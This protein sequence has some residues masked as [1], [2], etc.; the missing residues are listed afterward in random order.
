MSVLAAVIVNL[1]MFYIFDLY[2]IKSIFFMSGRLIR[3]VIAVI[4]AVAALTIIL[5][6][7]T[8]LRITRIM[9]MQAPLIILL[10]G[11]WR[12]LFFRFSLKN[13]S[14]SNVA[15]VGDDL[16]NVSII[17]EIEKERFPE[18]NVVS[19]V[20]GEDDLP[21]KEKLIPEKFREL[22]VSGSDLEDLIQKK[23]IE[24]LVFSTVVMKEFTERLLFLKSKG[25]KIFDSVTFFKLVAGRVPIINTEASTISCLSEK[26]PL[27]GYYKNIKRI[28]DICLSLFGIVI[29]FPFVFISAIF[30]NIEAPGPIFF[31]PERVGEFGKIIRLF[32]LRTMKYK[33]GRHPGPLFTQ[34]NDE[35]VTRIGEIVRK[36]GFDEFP[37][38]L[39]VLRGDLSLIGPRPIEKVFVDAYTEKT[40]LYYLRTSIKP[41][42]SGWA[43]VNQVEYPNSDESQLIKLEYDLFYISHASLF[44]DFVIIFKTIK[45][46]FNF[47]YDNRK[48]G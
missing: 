25:V 8:K 31:R 13:F 44:L 22:T 27:P 9:L 34:D 33:K 19:I 35:R 17:R 3:I 4:M 36:F 26:F 20:K 48:T 15:L 24:I 43:Q 16:L 5:Y 29:S 39:N 18:Y 45:K 23:Q 30:I 38:L 32:K 46:F 14:R 37:Q 2:N 7:P 40:P 6:F 47:G 42:I 11:I 1:L 28:I 21:D 41:G 10:I 12:E